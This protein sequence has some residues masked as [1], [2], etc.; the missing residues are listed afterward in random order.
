MWAGQPQSCR[1]SLARPVLPMIWLT[2]TATILRCPFTDATTRAGPGPFPWGPGIMAFMHSDSHKLCF[3]P[4]PSLPPSVFRPSL[5]WRHHSSRKP[6]GTSSSFL[7]GTNAT[8]YSLLSPPGA[9]KM[10]CAGTFNQDFLDTYRVSGS[11][12]VMVN[13]TDIVTF[14]KKFLTNGRERGGRSTR[15]RK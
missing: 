9:G 7:P 6:T 1:A 15:I 11:R 12:D 2:V 3:L 8:C 5:P 10:S 13:K 14:L 4:C